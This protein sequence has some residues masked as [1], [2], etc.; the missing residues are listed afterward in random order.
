MLKNIFTLKS[1]FELNTI[2]IEA[3]DKFFLLLGVS[4]ILLGIVLK[5]AAR[6]APTPVDRKY[7]NQ[8]FSWIFYG[9]L[10]EFFWYGARSQNIRLFGL[11]VTALVIL[12]IVIL[13]VFW[14]LWKI[15]KNYKSEKINWEKEEVKNK[16]LP[17]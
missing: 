13:G 15:W 5:I 6:L 8:L 10:A 12:I 4:L 2:S 11:R 7:R 17:K 3:A 1:L 9:G 14:V 16:Y